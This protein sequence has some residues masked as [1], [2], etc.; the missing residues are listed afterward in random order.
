DSWHSSSRMLKGGGFGGALAD[1]NEQIVQDS[2]RQRT[3]G[4]AVG[5]EQTQLGGKLVV[6]TGNDDGQQADCQGRG[7]DIHGGVATQVY[8]AQH[9][10]AHGAHDGKDH[11]AG[12]SNDRGR[13]DAD[14]GRQWREHAEQNQEQSTDGGD[15]AGTHLGG[16]D[17]ADVLATGNDQRG[18]ENPAQQRSQPVASDRIGDL[19]LLLGLVFFA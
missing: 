11:Q 12:C 5:Q 19:C 3:H 4:N 18:S 16:A 14:Q 17:D 10:Y 2:R 8:L 1:V 13:D 9:V 15:I 6:D 7:N